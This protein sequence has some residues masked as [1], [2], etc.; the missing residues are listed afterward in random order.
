MPYTGKKNFA[1]T[2]EYRRFIEFAPV[3]L[4]E[5]EFNPPRFVWVNEETCKVLGHTSEE[6][7]K[8]NPLDVTDEAGKQLSSSATN[9]LYYGYLVTKHYYYVVYWTL[10]FD[11]QRHPP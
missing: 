3:G 5:I 8:M 7:L 10:L 2:E 9:E 1:E 6:L 4:Y 11:I